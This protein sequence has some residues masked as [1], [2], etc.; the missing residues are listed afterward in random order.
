[1]TSAPRSTTW[2][3]LEVRLVVVVCGVCGVCGGGVVV[4]GGWGTGWGG[5]RG[6]ASGS[7]SGV[8]DTHDLAGAPDKAVVT[9]LSP[10]PPGP[11]LCCQQTKHRM[12]L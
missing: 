6:A 12:F 10:Y 11:D 1:M 4:V 3:G 7:A 5:G 8:R 9:F 2:N